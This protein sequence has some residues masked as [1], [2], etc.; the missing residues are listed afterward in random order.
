MS[1]PAQPSL[2]QRVAG[3]AAWN[4]LLFP[5]RLVVGLVASVLLALLP[6]AEYGVLQLL[7]GLAATIGLYADPGIERSLPRFLPEVE[8][9]GGR[10]A[11]ARFL[12]RIIAVK[13]VL[14]LLC[15]AGL[16][17]FSTPL[18][19]Y[20]L[21][22]E[23]RA[24]QQRDANL[25]ALQ[26][27]GAPPEQL[28]QQ[29][30]E[31]DSQANVM[32]LVQ[33]RGSLF[34]WAVAALVLFGALYDIFM[35]FLTAYFKQRAWNVITILVTL[36]QPAL[37]IV[38]VLLGWGLSGVLLGMVIT[39]VVAVVLAAGQTLRAARD[40]PTTTE[41]PIMDPTFVP[42]FAKF[43]GMSYFIQITGWFYDVQFVTFTL[44]ALGLPLDQVALLVFGY[45]FAKDYLGYVYTPF[46]GVITPLLARIRGRTDPGALHESYAS[47][48]RIFALLLIPA[49]VGLAL[50][51]PWMLAILYPQYVEAGTLIVIFLFFS[52]LESL[53]SIPHNILMVYERYRPVLLARLLALV[54]VPLLALLVPP[55]G[56]IGAA[57]AVGIARVLARLTTIAYLHRQMGMRAPL[58]FVGRVL[59][60]TVGFALPLG[61]LFQFWPTPT[62]GGGWLE[63]LPAALLLLLLILVA[64]LLYLAVLRALG[65]L[66][67]AERRRILSLRLPFKHVLAKF[68]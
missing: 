9:H 64:G 65:G 47:L 14:V 39:P 30:A 46:N 20:V 53:L 49:G 26:A 24:L 51:T 57:F 38:F 22:S 12:R 21:E 34:L 23:Q 61:L 5:A 18:I 45:K 10:A 17:A 63:K 68:L 15:I 36:I 27:Q 3:A 8:Q 16:L 37:I 7:V 41:T 31:R 52:F 44:F 59:A 62:L 50:I 13:L 11:V 1:D 32:T 58:P 60:A 55:F 48:T 42:R 29:Q 19:G 54:S 67:E 33:E 35:Q 66:D 28:V 25:A 40:L 43:A 6:R 2:S 56:M 4:A